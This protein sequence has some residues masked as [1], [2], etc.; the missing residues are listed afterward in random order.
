MAPGYG[1]GVQ[2]RRRP[3][4]SWG[5]LVTAVVI[6]DGDLW[7]VS[8]WIDARLE[9]G[10]DFETLDELVR[11]ADQFVGDSYPPGPHREVAEVQYAIY[12][13]SFTGQP[14][15]M[16]DVTSRPGDLIATDI[17]GSTL[18]V[19]GRS[20]EELISQVASLRGDQPPIMFRWVKK[21]NEL[22][23]AY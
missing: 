1:A 21:V 20:A 23:D 16:L 10:G 17:G 18:E 14:E 22:T 15:V 12:P 7:T 5:D 2:F 6:R 4:Q 19:R 8:S 9:A 11:T 13:W 3:G